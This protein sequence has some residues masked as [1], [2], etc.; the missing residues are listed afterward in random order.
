[1]D[2]L[3]RVFRVTRALEM[4]EMV[5]LLK[6][7]VVIAARDILDAIVLADYGLLYSFFGGSQDM[8][9]I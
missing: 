5:H 1:V 7:G 9:L 2:A 4:G 6:I 8:D 3:I